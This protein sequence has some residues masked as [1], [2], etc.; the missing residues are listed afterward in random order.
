MAS[1]QA[2]QLGWTEEFCSQTFGGVPIL[3]AP[4][5]EGEHQANID[6][7]NSL[8]ELKEKYDQNINANP[9]EILTEESVS[10]SQIKRKSSHL[11]LVTT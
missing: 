4:A 5:N 11:K 10:E 9:E 3:L 8:K 1:F 6:Y 2:T 7:L